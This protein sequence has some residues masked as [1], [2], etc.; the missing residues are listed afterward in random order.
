MDS[1]IEAQQNIIDELKEDIQ[2]RVKKDLA[3]FLK[4]KFTDL[5]ASR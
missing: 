3:R 4:M 2:N 5:S 1:M